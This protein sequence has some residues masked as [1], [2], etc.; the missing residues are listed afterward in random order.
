MI[1]AEH[2]D[3]LARF[4]VEHPALRTRPPAGTS[5]FGGLAGRHGHRAG[6]RDLRRATPVQ[7]GTH[8]SQHLGQ[9]PHQ[10]VSGLGGIEDD[11]PPPGCRQDG[12]EAYR[13][14]LIPNAAQERG[15]PRIAVRAAYDWAVAWAEASWWQR[16]AEATYGIPK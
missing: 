15:L 11:Q 6:G 12:I 9:V 10:V 3:R 5:S 14:A 4:G 8:R 7:A 16:K 2:R 13:F 1:V